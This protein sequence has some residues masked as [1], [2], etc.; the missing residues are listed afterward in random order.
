[1]K[2][3]RKSSYSAGKSSSVSHLACLKLPSL[4]ESQIKMLVYGQWKLIQEDTTLPNP[5]SEF[6]SHQE[7][8][9][10]FEY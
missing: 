4:R 6:D 5:T 10:K 8:V 2:Q 7:N 9:E 3:F 1:M